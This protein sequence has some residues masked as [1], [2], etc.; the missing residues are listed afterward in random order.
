MGHKQWELLYDYEGAS[1]L[2]EVMKFHLLMKKP[3]EE[4][5]IIAYEPHDD[6]NSLL[7]VK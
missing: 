2:K 5:M 4:T 7:Y 3:D 6:Y 1:N